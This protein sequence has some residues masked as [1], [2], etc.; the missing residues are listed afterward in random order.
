[1]V[2]G[3]VGEVTA[4]LVKGIDISD[5]QKGSFPAVVKRGD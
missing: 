2:A 4:C 3:S 5:N 1:M